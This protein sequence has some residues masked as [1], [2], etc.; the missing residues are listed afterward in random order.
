MKDTAPKRLLFGFISNLDGLGEQPGGK[1]CAG[2]VFVEFFE[3]G[4]EDL[5]GDTPGLG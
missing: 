2:E 3:G 4:G 1:I 5:L